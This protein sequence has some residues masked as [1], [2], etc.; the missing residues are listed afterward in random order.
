MT[1]VRTAPNVPAGSDT[2]RWSCCD[3]NYTDV[4][5]PDSRTIVEH[6]FGTKQA[7]D[8]LP[9]A[10]EKTLPPP[11]RAWRIESRSRPVGPHWIA[12]GDVPGAPSPKWR[13]YSCGVARSYRDLVRKR[14]SGS[15]F[16][17]STPPIGAAANRDRR[18]RPASTGL[19]HV[20][21]GFRSAELDP[22]TFSTQSGLRP[23]GAR[24]HPVAAE[25]DSE[26][27]G[28]GTDD[29]RRLLPLPAVPSR[30]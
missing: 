6:L 8:S 3:L 13:C 30:P 23:R 25:S 19:P 29:L 26:S 7:D 27:S 11:P 20:R 15:G 14:E 12:P 24:I 28:G 21:D 18:I 10:S 4:I 5:P 2:I 1:D 17:R 16:D 9:W 22:P